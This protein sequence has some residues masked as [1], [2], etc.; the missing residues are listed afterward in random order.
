MRV[1]EGSLGALKQFLF[2]VGV[3]MTSTTGSAADRATKIA[4]KDLV[5]IACSL[6][7]KLR[8]R[9]SETD[10][11]AKLPDATIE[12]FEK[13][14]LFDMVVPKMYGGLQSALGTYMDVLV[15]IGRG[16]G[17]AAWTLALLSASTWMATTLYP[18][19]VVDEIYAAGE[20]IRVAGVI[21]PREAKTRPVDGGVVIEN[22]LWAFNSGVQHAQ[23]DVLGI[24]IFDKAGRLVDNGNALI[25]ISDVTLLHDW[26][27]IGLRGSGSTSVSV[28]DIFVPN[29]RIALRSRALREDYASTHL[30]DQP[31][32]RLPLIPFLA[33]NL[34]VPMLGMAKAA[35]EL[36]LEKAP[37]RGIAFTFYQRQD[38]AAVTHLQVGEASSKIDA[39]ELIVARAFDEL[40]ASSLS[41]ERL[42]VEQRA[43]IRRDAGFANQ[44]IWEAVDLLAG[45]SGG[46]FAHVRNPMN[47][48]WRDV[49]V[50]G[51]HGGICISTTMEL[52]GRILCGKE[53]NT[54]LL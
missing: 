46:S 49:R 14:R 19:P 33:T 22:G 21:A 17:S 41:G 24:P 50:A 31:L 30:R 48:L 8:S 13:A 2:I 20:N 39:A 23:W 42:S 36:T 18:K 43:R 38:E 37:N 29:E 34:V 1:R 15:Q 44:L 4:D 7:P 51:L 27:T 28:K 11:L 40:E 54:L 47:R 53:P 9:S 52:F 25:P 35:L 10:A 5:A 12:D 6:V 16:D 45:A 3:I 26:D 32:Y